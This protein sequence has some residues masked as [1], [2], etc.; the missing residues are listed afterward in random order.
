MFQQAL[1]IGGTDQEDEGQEVDARVEDRGWAELGPWFR[2]PTQDQLYPRDRPPMR[3][4]VLPSP[5]SR[6][7][8][9]TI[10]ISTE[11]RSR[12]SRRAKSVAMKAGDHFTRNRAGLGRRLSS[13]AEKRR[14]E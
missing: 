7:D 13:Q 9:S 2:H 6:Y 12:T 4:R 5:E 3:A 10:K 1:W 11:E 8:A 14:V